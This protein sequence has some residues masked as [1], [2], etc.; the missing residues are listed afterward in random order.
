MTDN[1]DDPVNVNVTDTGSL[2]VSQELAAY[3]ANLNALEVAAGNLAGN[4]TGKVT[5]QVMADQVTV[6]QVLDVLLA[7][8]RVQ[9]AL[10]G[11]PPATRAGLTTLRALDDRLRA[12]ASV[13][14]TKVD[15]KAWHDIVQP[16]ASAWW[17]FLQPPVKPHWSIRFGWI[18]NAITVIWL[19]VTLFLIFDMVPRFPNLGPDTM[20]T[21]VTMTQLSIGILAAGSALTL[22]GRKLIDNFLLGVRVPKQ[23][24]G[25]AKLTLAILALGTLLVLRFSLGD[26]A[27]FYNNRAVVRHHAGEITY[28]LQDYERA[29]KLE[30]D[31]IEVHYNLG[32]LHEDLGNFE[33]AKVEYRYAIEGDL[34][35]AYVNLSRLYILE[36]KFSQAALLLERHLLGAQ[37]TDVRYDLLKNLGWARLGQQRYGEATSHL[38]QAIALDPNQAPAHC[39][40]AQ[41]Y[42]GSEE[43]ARALPEWEECLALASVLRLDEDTWIGMARQRLAPE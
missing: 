37:E 35:I 17:W 30:P 33:R 2:H 39:L 40:L 18:W 23:Y 7:R 24:L 28:A 42:E 1:Y 21:L 22:A 32:L 27:R 5:D 6:E 38:L 29:L 4:A 8:D 31:F 9:L 16:D 36:G 10:Q 25:E 12:L 26:F 20:N 34:D 15:P 11:R 14:H 41:S 13:I 43:T 3:S 19:I